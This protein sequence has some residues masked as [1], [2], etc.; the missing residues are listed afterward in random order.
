MN[1]RDRTGIFFFI[2]IFASPCPQISSSVCPCPYSSPFMSRKTC[3]SPGSITELGFAGAR[4]TPGSHVSLTFFFPSPTVRK[5][6]SNFQTGSQLNSSDVQIGCSPCFQLLKDDAVLGGGKP[7][8]QQGSEGQSHGSH[9]KV[10]P[11]FFTH[12]PP[13][14]GSEDVRRCGVWCQR[15]SLSR[16]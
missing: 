2:F 11:S 7:P 6:P 14:L 9:H 16:V 15:L 1:Y 8:L 12:S 4:F 13:I 5:P 10:L 3:L